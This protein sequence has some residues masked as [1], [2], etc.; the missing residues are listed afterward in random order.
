MPPLESVPSIFFS[1]GFELSDP[2]TFAEVTEQKGREEHDADPSALAHSL[3]LLEKLSHYADTV[4]QHLIREISLRSSSFFAAL[5]N[6]NELQTESTQCLERVRSLRTMLK[7]VDEKG[8]NKG[9]KVIQL[10]K[11]LQNMEDVQ[12][13]VK[14]MKGVGE[15]LGVA[16]NLAHGGE[17]GAAL[18]VVEELETSWDPESPLRQKVAANLRSKPG[19]TTALDSVPESPIEYRQS[20][21]PAPSPLCS[22]SAF[23]SLPEQLRALTSEIATSLTSEVVNVLKVDLITVMDSQAANPGAEN[24]RTI[25]DL[26]DRLRPLLESLRRT[27]GIRNTIHSWREAVL[28]HVR[29]S[30]K[31]VSKHNYFIGRV[32]TVAVPSQCRGI[33]RR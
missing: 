16:K 23:A 30:A 19:R 25:I 5:T 33:G 3:P 1:P 2:R 4:E 15:L 31:Q 28:I 13:A 12:E 11:K 20:A 7:E 17:L 24:D 32:L 26:R 14:S 29:A 21:Q 10:E 6:L 27:H 18:G 9:L 8:A 22:L